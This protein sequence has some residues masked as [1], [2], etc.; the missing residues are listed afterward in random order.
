MTKDIIDKSGYCS[1]HKSYHCE[2][3]RKNIKEEKE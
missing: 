2:C 3:Y 1:V